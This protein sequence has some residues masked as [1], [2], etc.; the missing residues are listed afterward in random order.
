MNS[1]LCE[2]RRG[3][4]R[5]YNDQVASFLPSVNP[6]TVLNAILTTLPLV[7]HFDRMRALPYTFMVVPTEIYFPMKTMLR[8]SPDNALITLVFRIRNKKR[9]TY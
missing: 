5:L 6:F 2:R 1:P 8:K 7:S 3:R 9:K 4:L